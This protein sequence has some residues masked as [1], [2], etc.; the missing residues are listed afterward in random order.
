ML[1]FSLLFQNEYWEKL[2]AKPFDR[3]SDFSRLARFLTGTSVALVLGGGGARGLSQ[4]GILY[5]IISAGIIYDFASFTVSQYI[6]ALFGLCSAY[7][8]SSSVNKCQSLS[9]HLN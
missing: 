2:I 5:S 8:L 7:Y 1:V 6:D 4:I 9:Q 3:F